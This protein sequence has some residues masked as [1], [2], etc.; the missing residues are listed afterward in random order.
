MARKPSCAQKAL[1]EPVTI[2]PYDPEWPRLFA[3]ESAQLRACLPPALVG[4]IEHF[5]STAVPGLAAK[6]VVDMLVEV[7]SLEVVQTVIAPILTARGYE[8]FWRPSWQNPDRPEYAWFIKRDAGG[9]RTHHIHMLEPQSS[10]WERVL[11]RDYLIAHPELAEEYGA[12][13]TRIAQAFP[14]DRIG[15]AKAKTE[16]ITRVTAAARSSADTHRS[17]A[18]S[19]HPKRHQPP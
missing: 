18:K 19:P 15:Y 12:L 8:Y 16:F 10:E 4:R 5:G 6:P 9:K 1:A 14:N 7:P 13:K 3:A 2:S 17:E 11:F